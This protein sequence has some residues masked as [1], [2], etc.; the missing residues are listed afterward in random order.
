M[1][2]EFDIGT[3][4]N[5]YKYIELINTG[6]LPNYTPLYALLNINMGHNT[7][8]LIGYNAHPH[9]SHSHIS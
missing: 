4:T 6:T 1:E 5:R 7:K 3:S 2:I 8:Q 9:P